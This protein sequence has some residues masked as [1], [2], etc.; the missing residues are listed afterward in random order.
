M[1]KRVS[2]LIA[3]VLICSGCATIMPK[4]KPY[5]PL[6][7]KGDK[8]LWPAV[9]SVA[10][11]W[12]ADCA[13]ADINIFTDVYKYKNCKA[14]GS[15]RIRSHTTIKRTGTV[16]TVD[17]EMEHYD[18]QKGGWVKGLPL[19]ANADVEGFKTEV[20]ND[21]KAILDSDDKYKQTKDNYLR[22][23]YFH[24]YVMQQMTTV[25]KKEWIADLAKSNTTFEI[26]MILGDVVELKQPE[27]D[28]K[29][30][31]YFFPSQSLFGVNWLSSRIRLLTNNKTVAYNKKGDKVS[32]K[33]RFVSY[34]NKTFTIVGQ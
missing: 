10:G 14:K 27:H 28:S 33:G 6:D 7:Y 2:L 24:V 12:V 30:Q 31:A 9:L 1:K 20:V 21:I 23:F 19:L 3:L 16:L 25:A 22:N 26:E 32:T 29:Y 34:D 13:P 17:I 11:K 18:Q 15:D 4:S 8:K 5:Q